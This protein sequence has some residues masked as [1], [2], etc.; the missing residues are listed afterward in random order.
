M[1]FDHLAKFIV[2]ALF[3]LYAFGVASG[4]AVVHICE[5]MK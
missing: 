4:I 5:L 1:N 3:M 2:C